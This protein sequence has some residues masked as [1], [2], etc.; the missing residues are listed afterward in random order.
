[1]HKRLAKQL[2]RARLADGS[3][4]IEQLS[5]LVE[6]TY[7][8]A[9]QDRERTD[10]S[11]GLMV[12]ELTALQ[13][14]LEAEIGRQTAE[15][16]K[17]HKK[18]KT[19]N[20]RFTAALK[21][22]AHGLSMYDVR[23]RLV[24]C[25]QMFLDIYRLPRSL[26][27]PGTSF[28]RILEARIVSN[29]YIGEDPDTYVRARLA[30]I[31]SDQPAANTSTLNT[32]QVISVTHT[33][34]P[35]GGWVSTHKDITEL[36][37]AQQEL[38]HLAYHDGLT[39][40]PNRNMLHQTVREAFGAG[41]PGFAVLCVDLDGFKIIND[42]FGHST[43]DQLL[44]HVARRIE[45][46]A[47]GDVVGRMGGDEFAVYT[48]HGDA[49]SA[50]ALARHIQDAIKLP[51]DLD[52]QVVNVASSIGIALAPQDG[53][54]TD[55]L[56]KSGD[57]ALYAVKKERRGGFRFFDASMDRALLDRRQMEL[58][59]RQALELGEFE[60]HYQPI[61]NLHTQSF[62]G[63]EALLRWR[64]PERGMISPGEFIPIAE[65]LGLIVPI[66]EW[67][68]REA[69][70]EAARWPGHLRIAVNVSSI[71]FKRGNLVG[72]IMNTLATTGLAHDRV[73]IE[74][75]ESLFLENDQSNLEILRQ[76]HALGLKVAMDD[77]GTGYSALSY[78]LSFPFDKI[79][80]DGSFV[81]A[82][83]NAAGAHTIVR[84]V[85]D[86]GNRMGMT[87]TAEGI[88]TAEQLR[89]VH[90]V[91]YTEAQGFLISRPMTT[92]AVRRL[93]FDAHDAMPAAPLEATG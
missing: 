21:N 10:R 72:V 13:A 17:S 49:Q 64:H 40:L 92:E 39:D 56:L 63:F 82:L 1:M 45:E 20:T 69:F 8:E 12:E 19:Q 53:G 34:M 5:R 30:L 80:I 7:E 87:V 81:R 85:A 71:Q 35:G 32:G 78:L 22:M 31:G 9:E 46:A 59:L 24:T 6:L 15:L 65:E 51:F 73:E 77:F 29:T 88:E 62:T 4:D 54:T 91:G 90:A 50:S 42:T 52:G 60:L 33:P 79:K 48:A 18:L 25:N 93:L 3:L 43:G 74:I 16:K 38:K 55:R 70:A 37:T 28:R 89:N 76:L 41:G 57:L 83:D 23:G 67:V 58:D 47:P 84:A 26:A 75:T 11:I 14:G 27:R 66:G 61:L 2:T 68:I 86:I 36:H 44:R